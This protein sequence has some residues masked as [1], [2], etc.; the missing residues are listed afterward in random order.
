MRK[1]LLL[2][3]VVIAALSCLL[4]STAHA[5]SP[6]LLNPIERIAY[7]DDWR[8]QVVRSVETGGSVFVIAR[9]GDHACKPIIT[10]APKIKR[11]AM[12]PTT[13]DVPSGRGGQTG[14]F[15]EAL[16]PLN[17]VSC[18]L[19]QY[20]LFDWKPTRSG[21]VT[22]EID[23]TVLVVDVR[24]TKQRSR[25]ARPFFVGITNNHLLRAHCDRYCPREGE[26]GANYTSLLTSHG[27]QPIQGWARLPP[28]RNERLDL[29]AGEERGMSFR[30]LVMDVAIFGRIGFPRAS[31][32]KDPVAYLRAL[33]ATIHA[34]K[35][36]GRA[37]VYAV[38]E[39]LINNRLID[40]LK[41]YRLLAPSAKVM[42]T[43][44][45]S[46]AL[47]PYIDIFAPVYNQV[48]KGLAPRPRIGSSEFWSYPSCMGSCGPRRQSGKVITR[49]PGPDTGMA[50]FLIDRPAK[51]LFQFFK[52]ADA[53]KLDA[54]LYYEAT[55]PFRLIPAGHDLIKDAWNYGGNGDGLLVYPGRAGEYGLIRDQPLPSFR[56]K[57]IRYALQRWWGVFAY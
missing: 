28:I 8:Q 26:L 57:L 42:V 45:Y 17:P 6:A 36:Q 39:P 43:T 30:Q 22:I 10:S 37:W 13:I 9:V 27:V 46:K 41:T 38:D 20:I 51:R 15:Y 49:K 7:S 48:A 25:L 19:S 31:H 4:A 47:A 33:E 3:Y 14:D 24:V 52:D 35:L 18:R 53:L 34:E 29:D 50:D 12:L 2:N 55:E 11:F 23:G 54:G 1:L 5:R 44:P 16:V 32:Y 40:K 21:L 56:L